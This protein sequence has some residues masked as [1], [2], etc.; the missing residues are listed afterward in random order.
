MVDANK[1]K[2]ILGTGSIQNLAKDTDK[3]G[4]MNVVDCQPHNPNKQGWVHDLAEKA[5]QKYSEH[6]TISNLQRQEAIKEAEERGITTQQINERRHHQAVYKAQREREIKIKADEA[7]YNAKE[8]QVIK[9]AESKAH[10]G[11]GFMGFM[12]GM[13]NNRK[14]ARK[15]TARKTTSYKESTQY[16]KQPGGHYKKETVYKRVSKG[17]T[18]NKPTVNRFQNFM[19]GAPPKKGKGNSGIFNMRI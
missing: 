12:S 11:G 16:V 1:L 19:M 7:Y 8:K 6:K 18:G 5:R 4:V 10:G 14:Q 13:S 3:D 2:Q 9:S 17:G 15:T